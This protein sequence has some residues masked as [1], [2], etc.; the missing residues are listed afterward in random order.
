MLWMVIKYELYGIG[1]AAKHD[2]GFYATTSFVVCTD[3]FFCSL[4]TKEACWYEKANV[5]VFCSLEVG[6]GYH[7]HTL[8]P[9]TCTDAL[10][11]LFHCKLH[12]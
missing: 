5:N 6:S 9:T 12:V 3:A 10:E 4:L 8:N 7:G 1:M 2:S 11:R